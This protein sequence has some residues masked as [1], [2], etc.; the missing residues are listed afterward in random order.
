MPI[1]HVILRMTVIIV[2]PSENV[3]KRKKLK[4]ITIYFK[5]KK[6]VKNIKRNNLKEIIKI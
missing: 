5:R 3:S 2:K 6:K 4:T 1:V